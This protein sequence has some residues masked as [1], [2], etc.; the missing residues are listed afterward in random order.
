MSELRDMYRRIADL[1]VQ[2]L[3]LIEQRDAAQAEAQEARQQL[4]RA[5]TDMGEAQSE[6]LAAAVE[7]S[8]L[9]RLLAAREGE[10]ARVRAVIEERRA[11]A[12]P[13]VSDDHYAVLAVIGELDAALSQPQ[14]AQPAA[15]AQEGEALPLISSKTTE[16]HNLLCSTGDGYWMCEVGGQRYRIADTDEH[17]LEVIPREPG[18]PEWAKYRRRFTGMD[19]WI[20]EQNPPSVT[21][22]T[23][24]LWQRIED[25]RPQ[26]NSHDQA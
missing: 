11:W 16:Q 24:D 21:P 2:A 8:R 10:L 12:T 9:E 25:Y 22:L 1:E 26:E 18:M 14:P 7:A 15:Q 3:T 20:W 13:P 23:D 5:L 19:R 6:G 17:G 4:E